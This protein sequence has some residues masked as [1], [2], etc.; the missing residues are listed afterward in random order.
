MICIVASLQYTCT[1]TWQYVANSM[2][3]PARAFPCIRSPTLYSIFTRQQT[4]DQWPPED[5]ESRCSKLC[6]AVPGWD[7]LF[8]FW[9]FSHFYG[10]MGSPVWTSLYGL[11]HIGFGVRRTNTRNL[12]TL[13]QQLRIKLAC[14][15]SADWLFRYFVAGLLRN[16]ESWFGRGYGIV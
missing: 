1:F 16:K 12:G 7:A 10:Y 2:N 13:E 4:K 3:F 8:F 14:Y 9:A 15:S 6:I 11:F 5:T